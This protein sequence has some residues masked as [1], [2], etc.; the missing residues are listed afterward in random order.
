MEA[1]PDGK[2]WFGAGIG[3]S[4]GYYDPR[5]GE[6]WNSPAITNANGDVYGIVPYEGRF[7]FT[8]YAGGDHVVYDPAKPWDQYNNINPQTLKSVGPMHM[9]RPIAGSILG[10]D[11]N[12]W[13]G[14]CGTYGIYGGGISRIDVN[15]NEVTG[16]FGVVPEQSIRHM[17]ASD[18][19]LYATSHW[20]C[21]GLA[22]KFDQEF[23]LLRLDTA[24][25]ILWEEK[26]RV[27][28]F[29]EC[30]LI[31]GG[32]LYMSMRDRLDGMAKILV[33]DEQTMEKLTERVMNPLGG[34]GRYEME[35][36]A[37]RC[38]LPYGEDKLVVFIGDRVHLMDGE[39]LE[40]LQ[41]AK[42]PAM[43]ETYAVTEDLSV[44]C[45]I[46][47]KMFRVTFS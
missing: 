28:Q 2:V 5:T 43:A 32:K 4:V 40:I 37:I 29:P 1:A 38:L 19:Y 26:F 12:I 16:W 23:R 45:S 17:V 44:Y 11:G 21:S 33:Y 8:A 24:C 9:G 34:P 30:L 20:M 18:R 22:Y 15:T 41:T 6:S 46:D 27:G 35:E 3:E 39:S 47:E 25:N 7:Y 14:W 42:L 36:H 13:T 10:P 31:R